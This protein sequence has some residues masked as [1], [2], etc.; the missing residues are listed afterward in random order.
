[1]ANTRESA[2][3]I[4]PEPS[5]TLSSTST[6]EDYGDRE[7]DDDS[8]SHHTGTDLSL[9]QTTSQRPLE[10]VISRVRSRVPITFHHPL[11]IKK[12]TEDVIVHFDGPEDPYKALNW[13][14][15]KKIITTALYGLTTMTATWASSTFS[16]GTV[17]VSK[18]FSVGTQVATLG[19]S[20]F[21]FGFGIGPLLWAPL[22]EVYGRKLAVLAPMFVSACFCFGTAA[23]KDIQTVMITR[24]FAGFFSSA[25]VTNTGGVLG[26]LFTADKRGYAIAGYAMAVVGESSPWI[27]PS[28]ICPVTVSFERNR[29]F[30]DYRVWTLMAGT[31]LSGWINTS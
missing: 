28:G 21:L 18:E 26:D 11:S 23:A 30:P 25:P 2:Q 19:T 9:T 14:P 6:N 24:F 15:K 5:R 16:P 3:H 20:L 10:S 8:S 7:R 22:S 4:S 27:C 1:M 13:M 12:T 29:P 31:T 17:D